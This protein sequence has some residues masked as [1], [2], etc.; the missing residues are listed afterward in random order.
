MGYTHK[1]K[2][3]LINREFFNKNEFNCIYLRYINNS[4]LDKKYK[5]YI[6]YKFLKKFHL[7]SSSSRIV[8]RCIMTG[9]ANW[10]LRMFKLSRISFKEFADHGLINGVRRAVW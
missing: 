7:N 4:H 9:R 8:N 6:F 10:S 5:I 2:K 1:L 3:D